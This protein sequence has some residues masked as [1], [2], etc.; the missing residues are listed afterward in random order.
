MSRTKLPEPQAGATLRRVAEAAGVSV[1]TASRVLNNI[2]GKATPETVRRVRQ[3]A[4]QLAYRPL[5]AARGLRRGVAEMVALLAPN[6]ANPTMAGMAA[7][8]ETALRPEGIGVVLSDTHDQSALQDEALAATRA[9]RPRATVLLGAVASPGL[10]ACRRAG[11]R[12]LFV[13]R[14]CPGDAAAPFIGI[15][16]RAAGAAV[17][18]ALQEAGCRRLGAVHGPMFSSATADRVAGFVAAADP[19]LASADVRG[20]SGLDHFRIGAQAACAWLGRGAVPDGLMCTSDLIALAARR[21]LS[22]ARA[23]LPVIWGFDGGPL[24]PWIAPWLSSVALPYEAI[25]LA[26]RDWV[27]DAEAGG[28]SGTILPFSLQRGTAARGESGMSST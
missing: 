1:A 4:E 22:D 2:P 9:M 20:G 11:E 13:A 17:A 14:R 21:V 18:R 7:A 12:L 15:D 8:I 6:L 10:A 25:G 19:L 16:D 23:A 26:V 27:M 28:R 24:N 3:A 5:A